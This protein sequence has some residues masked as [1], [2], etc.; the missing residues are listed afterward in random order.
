MKKAWCCKIIKIP[1]PKSVPIA[2]AP[3]PDAEAADVKASCAG[4]YQQC[5]GNSWQG[6]KCCQHG[7]AC[8]SHGDYYS[9]CTPS[10]STGT[11]SQ[12]GPGR[13]KFMH[14]QQV[15]REVEAQNGPSRVRDDLR[16]LQRKS[17]LVGLAVMTLAVV[18]VVG[19]VHWRSCMQRQ[20]AKKRD[21]RNILRSSPGARTEVDLLRIDTP[22]ARSQGTQNEDPGTPTPYV[23]TAFGQATAASVSVNGCAKK[24]SNSCRTLQGA[25][26]PSAP[27]RGALRGSRAAEHRREGATPFMTF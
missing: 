11:C 20:E 26:A 21:S 19:T 6:P 22:N 23:A 4:A 25:P 2:T 14:H 24:E 13:P 17:A 8:Q 27:R 3:P 12:S 15:R 18:I 7:C 1:C 16:A 10:G 9:Q 5:G